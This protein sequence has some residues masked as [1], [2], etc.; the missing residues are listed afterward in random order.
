LSISFLYLNLFN[1]LN[2]KLNK[3]TAFEF[4]SQVL[5]LGDFINHFAK[6]YTRDDDDAKDLAQETMMKALMNYDKFRTNT[7]LKGWLRII[8]RNIFIN[9]Y[10]R[11]A[12]RL[13]KYDSDSFVVMQGEMDLYG[14]DSQMNKQL[15]DKAIDALA[16]DFRVPFIKHVEGFKYQEIADEMNLPIGTV[17]S[18]IFQ[19][20]KI[21]SQQLQHA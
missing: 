8:M 9:G 2:L 5:S 18:R 17:K 15:I 13:I 21:L 16:D 4:Q 10:R 3:M 14:P 12:Q 20:R 1:E 7:N 19:A 6:K 11:K